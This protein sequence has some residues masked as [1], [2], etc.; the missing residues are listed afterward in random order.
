MHTTVQQSFEILKFIVNFS[1]L[2]CSCVLGRVI[3]VTSGISRAAAPGRS[4]YSAS[5]AAMEAFMGCL[6]YEM[7]KF[8][9]KVS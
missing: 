3:T 5:K 6:R 8:G 2:T 4:P 1:G 7:T 9:V